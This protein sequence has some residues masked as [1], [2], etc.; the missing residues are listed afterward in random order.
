MYGKQHLSNDHFPA[1]KYKY[2]FKPFSFSVVTLYFSYMN[3]E[4][5][6][7]TELKYTC[8]FYYKVIITPITQLL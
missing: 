6:W 4:M 3:Y 5:N 1:H 2:F 8:S 7:N